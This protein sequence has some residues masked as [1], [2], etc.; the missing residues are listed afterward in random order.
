MS[1][2]YFNYFSTCYMKEPPTVTKE[3]LGIALSQGRLTQIEYDKIIALKEPTPTEEPMPT[4]ET[5]T[6]APPI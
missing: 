1:T 2:L 3:Q 6:E 4:E 5:P